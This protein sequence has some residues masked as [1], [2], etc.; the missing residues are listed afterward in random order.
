MER[1]AQG[2]GMSVEANALSST[3]DRIAAKPHLMIISLHDYFPF[4]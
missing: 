1:F 3:V 2:H 4:Q